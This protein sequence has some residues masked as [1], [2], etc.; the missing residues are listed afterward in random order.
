[1]STFDPAYIDPASEIDALNAGASA[2]AVRAERG[3]VNRDIL[4]DAVLGMVPNDAGVRECSMVQEYFDGK[5]IGNGVH[6][7]LGGYSVCIV[8]SLW[9]KHPITTVGL[10]DT[11]TAAVFLRELELT[12]RNRG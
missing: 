12:H 8:P 3:Y 2:S 11:M 7:T 4:P 9:C 6:L 1:V 5:N 10:G